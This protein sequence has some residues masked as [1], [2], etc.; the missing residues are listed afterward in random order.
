[1]EPGIEMTGL[2]IDNPQYSG[3]W[4]QISAYVISLNP[5]AQPHCLGNPFDGYNISS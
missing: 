2:Q 3:Y 5:A 1:M 4:L